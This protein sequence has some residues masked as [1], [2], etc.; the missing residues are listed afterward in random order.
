VIPPIPGVTREEKLSGSRGSLS[1]GV[2]PDGGFNSVS[3]LRKKSVE[4]STILKAIHDHATQTAEAPRSNAT[5]PSISAN[6]RPFS[7]DGLQKLRESISEARVPPPGPENFDADEWANKY[8]QPRSKDL[9]RIENISKC[10]LS[11][12]FHQ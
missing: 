3:N 12:K 8:L 2:S 10:M 6:R 11:L 5:R 1:A 4:S 7:N 9:K